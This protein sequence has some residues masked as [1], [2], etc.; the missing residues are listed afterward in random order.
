MMTQCETESVYEKIALHFS[1]TRTYT[2]SWVTFFLSNIE[3]NSTVYDI[4]C[5][6]G[7]NMHEHSSRLLMYGVDT[8]NAFLE[9]CRNKDLNVVKSCMT[10]LP[11]KN[12]SADSIICIA[13]FHHLKTPED[14]LCAL[15]EMER[16]LKKNG[17]I[18]LSFWSI[19]QPPKTRRV[20]T[21]YGDTIVPWN[22]LGEHYNRYYYIF[23]IEE[24]QKLVS[25]SG[26]HVKTHVYDCGNEVFT[27][28][29]ISN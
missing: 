5:G 2:W 4:G 16:V 11:F 7:R 13:S 12:N 1:N 23:E 19:H 3:E 26:L 9:I 28:G 15:K 17:T 29:K 14:R 24:F 22:K 27:L 21:K 18:L 6:N 20:F 8:C 10:S 25:D